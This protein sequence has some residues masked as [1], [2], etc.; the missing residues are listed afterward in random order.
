[1]TSQHQDESAPFCYTLPMRRLTKEQKKEMIE[2]SRFWVAHAGH[3]TLALLFGA[4]TL[5]LIYALW[6]NDSA[7]AAAI[8]GN[9]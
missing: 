3:W 4:F 2:Q 5:A 8:I 9:R 7:F 1:M 6:G